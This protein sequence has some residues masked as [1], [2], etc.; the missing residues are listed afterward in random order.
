M[1]L[2]QKP[3]P[4]G[5]SLPIGARPVSRAPLRKEAPAAPS[6]EPFARSKFSAFTTDG[7]REEDRRSQH[8]VAG[9]SSQSQEWRGVWS[10]PGASSHSAPPRTPWRELDQPLARA[11]LDDWRENGPSSA[12]ASLDEVWRDAPRAGGRAPAQDAFRERGP[13]DDAWRVVGRAPPRSTADVAWRDSA[14]APGRSSA[15]DAWRDPARAS[16][17]GPSGDTWHDSPRALERGSADD[18]V[19][20]PAR[21]SERGRGSDRAAAWGSRDVTTGVWRDTEARSTD[22]GRHGQFQN[23]NQMS[24][25][26]RPLPPPSRWRELESVQ[27]LEG[28]GLS[29]AATLVRLPADTLEG[30][31]CCEAMVEAVRAVLTMRST[32][33]SALCKKF[34]DITGLECREDAPKRSSR[35]RNA[36]RSRSRSRRERRRSRSHRGSKDVH[37]PQRQGGASRS[38]GE[39]LND[40]LNN[41]EDTARGQQASPTRERSRSVPHRHASDSAPRSAHVEDHQDP[42]Q[43]D[44]PLV[45]DPETNI[46]WVIVASAPNTSGQPRWRAEVRI[47]APSEVRIRT[48]NRLYK[49]A[50]REDVNELIE[51]FKYDGIQEVRRVQQTLCGND[52]DKIFS[53]EGAT[54]QAGVGTEPDQSE[55]TSNVVE[56]VA[57]A[58]GQATWRAELGVPRGNGQSHIPVRGPNR[59]SREDAENDVREFLD[60]WERGGIK[61]VRE[62]QRELAAKVYRKE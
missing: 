6:K 17:R 38:I 16:G 39:R 34:T 49:E 26:G 59:T 29:S 25:N 41:G 5:A 21:A 47:H 7:G 43:E 46:R 10:G 35:S 13:S 37:P 54:E 52:R 51:A 33:R 2:R 28:L 53:G 27:F 42:A 61:C 31:T 1:A 58:G 8:S 3:L 4:I 23:G 30:L 11:S 9:H 57:R 55:V 12:R 24:Q 62:V 14:R 60:G 44:E 48:P 15:D 20:D 36:R 19:R 50:V 40:L 32:D 18:G 22:T 56:G 45:V